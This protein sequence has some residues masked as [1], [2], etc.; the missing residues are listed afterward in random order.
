[1]CLL[2]LGSVNDSFNSNF[3]PIKTSIQF[4]IESYGQVGRLEV[5]K[6]LRLTKGRERGFGCIEWDS[7]S[8]HAVAWQVNMCCLQDTAIW[9]DFYHD[10]LKVYFSLAPQLLDDPISMY[11]KQGPLIIA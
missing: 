3:H 6:R 9:P 1:M 10:L 4:L 2:A 7:S 8:I 5:V 11:S